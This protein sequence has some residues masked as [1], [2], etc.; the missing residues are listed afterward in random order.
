MIIIQTALYIEAAEAAKYYGLTE[1]TDR[2]L[3]ARVFTDEKGLAAV[4]V[5]GTGGFNAAC[6]VASALTYLGAGSGD[7][8]VN[9]GIAGAEKDTDW[10]V[11]APG[12][13]VRAFKCSCENERPFYPD[14]IYKSPFAPA[15]VV[16]VKDPRSYSPEKYA[17]SGAEGLLP[18]VFDMEL[19]YAVKAANMFLSPEAL[20][21]FKTV[22]D[23]A[24]N[25]AS[26]GGIIDKTNAEKV[27]KDA[28]QSLFPVIDRT[29]EKI[30]E[31][32]RR[33]ES[34]KLIP[35]DTEK[36]LEALGN[37]LKLTY[38]GREMLKN[39]IRKDMLSGEDVNARLEA[40]VSEAEGSGLKNKKDRERFFRDRVMADRRGGDE[41]D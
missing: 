33:Q 38:A 12:D 17:C 36:L 23:Y 31:D 26:A 30:R 32:C 28:W 15:E 41:L 16:T 8:F 27:I 5:T 35:G 10:G 24:G 4:M 40:L 22:S 39:R 25:T 9:F 29:A 13:I 21:S 34:F 20:I 11:L 1:K 6:G 37:T 18:K 2:A 3:P 14:I 7:F 19:Y